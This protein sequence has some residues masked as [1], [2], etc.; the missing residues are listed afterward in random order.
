MAWVIDNSH[1]SIE[2]AVKHMMI[3]TVK[4]RFD[5]YT[6]TVNLDEERPER[7]TAEVTVDLSSIDTRDANRDAHLRSADFFN[8][9]THPRMTFRS[10]RVEP[11]G[12]ARYRLIGDL[13]ILGTSREVAF[14]ITDEGKMKDPWGNTKWGFTGQ[15]VINRKDFGLSWNVAL[16][17]GGVLVGEQVRVA[18]EI[19]LLQ[20]AE[21]PTGSAD[22]EKVA[23]E[24][25]A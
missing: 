7:S 14:D 2:F 21:V 8:A 12:P 24:V 11:V 10:S 9:E 5:S 6:G 13:D 22:A 19:E 17:A 20:Q 25:S 18:L 4:G 16:E 15:T 3:S 23:A 1:S